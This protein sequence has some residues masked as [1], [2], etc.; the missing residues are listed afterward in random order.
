MTFGIFGGR[1][2]SR[3]ELR[4]ENYANYVRSL[5]RVL[6]DWKQR[7]LE[8]QQAL[9][10]ADY[11]MEK[12]QEIGRVDGERARAILEEHD[13]DDKRRIDMKAQYQALK[14]ACGQKAPNLGGEKLHQKACC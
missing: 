1:E 2:K 13:I 5:D 3:D 10:H 7:E 4:D 12:I 11:F 8:T 14:T 6:T 9:V